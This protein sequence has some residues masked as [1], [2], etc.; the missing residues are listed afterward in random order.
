MTTRLHLIATIPSRVEGAALE[1]L[2]AATVDSPWAPL[3]ELAADTSERGRVDWGPYAAARARAILD[4]ERRIALLREHAGDDAISAKVWNARSD[5]TSALFVPIAR[6]SPADPRLR[7]HLSR[8]LAAL[9]AGACASI[10]SPAVSVPPSSAA[11]PVPLDDAPWLAA[12]SPAFVAAH[13]ARDALLAAPA[14]A[15]EEASDGTIWLQLYRDPIAASASE[16]AAIC[17]YLLAR[18]RA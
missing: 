3:A 18:A 10:F 13:F 16:V 9:P 14:A 7:A 15:I 1:P 4:G 5:T 2:L 12:L 11:L 17:E 6:T 8:V